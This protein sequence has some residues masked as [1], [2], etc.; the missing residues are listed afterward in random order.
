[1]ISSSSKGNCYVIKDK[2]TSILIEAGIVIKEIKESLNF[3]LCEIDGCLITHS[4]QDHCKGVQGILKAGVPAHMS[5]ETASSLNLSGHNVNIFESKKQFKINTLTVLPFP[6]PHDVPNHG[7]LIQSD[8][9]DRLA[10]I[11]DCPYCA[12]TF[13]SVNYFMVGCNFQEEIL[14]NNYEQGIVGHA[15]RSRLIECHMSLRQCVNFL[16]ANDLSTTRAIYLIHI[17]KT[18]ANPEEMK[19]KVIVEFGKP[20]IT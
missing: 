11:T 13:P 8:D 7:F 9:G 18:N 16:K 2:K 4:H 15:L 10:Y 6:V 14:R 17:S 19:K 20:V 1:M 3:R 12:Y 5:R